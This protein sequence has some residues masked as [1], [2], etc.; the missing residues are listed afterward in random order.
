VS[1]EMGCP[2]HVPA[3]RVRAFEWDYVGSLDGLYARLDAMQDGSVVVWAKPAAGPGTWMLTKEEVIRRAL[4]DPS[5]FSNTIGVEG[6]PMLIPLMMDAPEHTAYRRLLQPLFS[7]AAV[8]SLEPAV[9]RRFRQLVERVRDRGRCDFVRDIA[10]RYPTEIFIEW[11]GLP[12]EETAGYVALVSSLIH[13]SSDERATAPQRLRERLGAMIQER[14][15]APGEGLMSDIIRLEIDGRRL[16][17][18]ELVGMTFLL[19]IA[20]LDTVVAALSFS[21]AHLAQSGDD[22]RALVD[23]TVPTAHA[24]EELLR[25]HSFVSM[26]RTIAQDVV[27]DGVTLR[28]GDWVMIPT[29]LASRDPEVLECP[30]DIDFRRE[31]AHNYAF[32]LGSHFCLGAHLARLEMRVALDEWHAAI[33][34]Y[35]LDGEPEAYGSFVMGLTRLPLR[36]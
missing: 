30:Y 35:E 6:L 13:G 23:G 18:D 29:A 22:R 11:M 31:N 26:P 10:V 28:Q 14:L 3:D 34:D 20:G 21:M 24:V 33:P 16:T 2:A 15:A 19:F 8:A 27:L 1:S 32:G 25:R 12:E 5:V 4:R 7:K 36:W 17:P 9:Q